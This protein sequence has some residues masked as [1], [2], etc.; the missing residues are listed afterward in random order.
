MLI[1]ARRTRGSRSSRDNTV[2]D[3]DFP[4]RFASSPDDFADLILE[5]DQHIKQEPDDTKMYSK[6]IKPE[7]T[8]STIKDPG[9]VAY[10][11]E[12][13]NMALLVTG[14]DEPVGAVHYPLPKTEKSLSSKSSRMDE[15]ELAILKKR[16][17]LSLP[18]KELC[19]ELVHAF[20]KWIAPIVPIINRSSFMQR[21]RD[22][23]N[24]PSMLLMQTI[25]LAGSRVCTTPMLLDGNDSSIPVSTLFY[26]RAKALYDADYEQDRVTIVQALILMGWYWEDAGKVT[27]NVFYWNGLATTIA[28]GC[29]MH[30]ST[31]HSRLSTS[32]KRLWKRIWWTLFTR[33]RSVAAALGRPPHIHLIDSDVEM[34]CEEDF[35][36]EGNAQPDP[37]L[38]HFFLQYV[39]ICDVMD[40]VLLQNYSVSSRGHQHDAMALTQCDMALADWLQNCPQELR[41]GQS[42]YS[43][44]R[45]YLYCIYQTTSCLLHRAH[46]PP[47]PSPP[48]STSLSRSPAFQSAHA[49]TSVMES[50]IAHNEL[51][52]SPPNMYVILLFSDSDSNI[53]IG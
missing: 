17:A 14:Y 44:W 25:F 27:K 1:H 11:A 21:Y 37:L 30:R 40:L 13:S 42:R 41:W 5:A 45:A 33:D 26:Q 50:L 4:E 8:K 29:G 12:Q 46:L 32:D 52:Y 34:I 24:P 7:T 19:D 6:L 9:R 49:I 39:K 18:P 16:G 53:F 31:K 38:V 20:F 2:D 43:F 48:V 47:V 22:S 3:P 51:R 36:E 35:M 15:I 23:D 10:L 28:Q